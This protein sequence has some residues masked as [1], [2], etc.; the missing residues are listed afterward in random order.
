MSAPRLAL[1]LLFVASMGS[2]VG[3]CRSGQQHS[4]QVTL[5]FDPSVDDA[6]LVAV[7]SLVLHASGDEHDEFP[8]TI[9]R[10]YARTERVT[11]AADEKTRMLGLEVSAFDAHGALI[12]RGSAAPIS[13]SPSAAVAIRVTLSAVQAA[14]DGGLDMAPVD[15]ASPVLAAGNLSTSNVDAGTALTIAPPPGTVAG[16]LLLSM[17]T[18]VSGA[19]EVVTITPPVGW[20]TLTSVSDPN[21]GT[22]TTT[23]YYK[24]AG[25]SEPDSYTF[26]RSTTTGA[27]GLVI[28]FTGVEPTSPFDAPSATS[29]PGP[30]YGSTSTS[31]LHTNGADELVVILAT[32]PDVSSLV[33]NAPAMAAPALNILQASGFLVATMPVAT[34]TDI[35]AQVFQHDSGNLRTFVLTVALRGK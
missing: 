26:A 21:N 18:T 4:A 16:M 32:S 6:A 15:L 10:T 20:K 28:G 1:F 24:L 33:W 27:S 29:S 22:A 17:V 8:I 2:L 12:A 34:S 13:I 14:T 25:G 9:G 3:A 35:A 5:T 11:Y 31:A 19:G 30:D 23:W 7:A